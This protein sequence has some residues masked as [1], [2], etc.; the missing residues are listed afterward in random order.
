MQDKA[1]HVW[2]RNVPGFCCVGEGSVHPSFDEMP[3]SPF[4]LCRIF[5]EGPRVGIASSKVSSLND[6]KKHLVILHLLKGGHKTHVVFANAE[7]K[8]F[9]NPFT[10]HFICSWVNFTF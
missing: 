3:L 7:K 10:S 2:M 1:Q 5:S 9:K 4:I 6:Y 8:I